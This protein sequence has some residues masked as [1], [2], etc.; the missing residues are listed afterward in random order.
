[1]MWSAA[2]HIAEIARRMIFRSDQLDQKGDAKNGWTVNLSSKYDCQN[3]FF[4]VVK[5][6]L[7]GLDR[8]EVAIRFDD[9][10]KIADFDLFEKRLI[11]EMKFID[12]A[13]KKAEVV[14]TLDGLSRFYAGNANVGCLLFIIFV[15]PNVD[16]DDARW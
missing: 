16:L 10:E 9:Q 7:P 3:L 12:S 14:K 13:A 6:W 5:P 2:A 15:K 11:I 1:M 8:E 4:T